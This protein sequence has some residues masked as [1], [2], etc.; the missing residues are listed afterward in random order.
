MAGGGAKTSL[1]QNVLATWLEPVL[2][3]EL[4]GARLA[5]PLGGDQEQ[6]VVGTDVEPAVAA[7]EGERFPLAA[8]AGVDDGEV[9]SSGM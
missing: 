3:G 8:D 1:V 2:G 9:H 6:P 4:D 5:Q 7:A